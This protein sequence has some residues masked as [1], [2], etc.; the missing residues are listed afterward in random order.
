MTT[1]SAFTFSSEP[2][3]L[4]ENRQ[5]LLFDF[6]GVLVDS[7]CF[8]V[9]LW[10]NILAPYH[11]NFEEIDLTGKTN[12]QFLS[13][14]NFNNAELED[15]L[16]LKIREEYEFFENKLIDPSLF[17][18]LGNLNQRFQM[19]IV[20]NN[21]LANIQAYL[22]VN[23]CSHYFP[24]IISEEFGLA[25]KP[26]PDSYLKALAYF[27]VE[28]NQALIIEDS[29][30]GFA[31]AQNAEIDYFVFDQQSLKQSIQSFEIAM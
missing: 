16:D 22:T 5:V 15:L 4:F 3:K 20:S 23:N 8:Y 27:G 30:I 6:D 18:L 28:K 2:T 11:I 10:K 9:G 14:F 13:L 24:I 31:S 1:S 12:M 19:G 17:D 26:S 7:E 21:K 25:A 29:A